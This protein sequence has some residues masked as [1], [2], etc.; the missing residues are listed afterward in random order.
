MRDESLLCP[1]FLCPQGHFLAI[2]QED[3]KPALPLLSLSPGHKETLADNK[4][5][6]MAQG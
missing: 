2:P 4:P 6:G 5:E 1:H 3:T